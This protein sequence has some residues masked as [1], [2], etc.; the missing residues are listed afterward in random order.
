MAQNGP[1]RAKRRNFDRRENEGDEKPGPTKGDGEGGG[2]KNPL[3]KP[4]VGGPKEGG[5]AGPGNLDERNGKLSAGK[6]GQT[7]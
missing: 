1:T 2:W 7:G 4:S 5:T 6:E 3:G